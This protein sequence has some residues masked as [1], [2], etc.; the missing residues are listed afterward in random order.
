MTTCCI[1]M[2]AAP[3]FL[4]ISRVPGRRDRPRASLRRDEDPHGG[5]AGRERCRTCSPSTP[6]DS[7]QSMKADKAGDKLPQDATC[8]SVGRHV[9]TR[10]CRR[11]WEE[12]VNLPYDFGK[13]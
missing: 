3:A 2:L 10:G 11:G 1:L 7:R 13:K 8:V 9:D 6:G 4:H 12:D 5:F